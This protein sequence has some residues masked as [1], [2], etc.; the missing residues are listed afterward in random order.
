MV[1]CPGCL[2]T[3]RNKPNRTNLYP[4]Q[5]ISFNHL[6]G[7]HTA[8]AMSFTLDFWKIFPAN[9]HHIEF[10]RH[11]WTAF[12]PG[13]QR[14]SSPQLEQNNIIYTR[15]YLDDISMYCVSLSGGLSWE[16]MFRHWKNVIIPDLLTQLGVRP[17]GQWRSQDPPV[18]PTSLS[19]NIQAVFLDSICIEKIDW[20]L[21][22]ASF[23][24]VLLCMLQVGI[25]VLGEAA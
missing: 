1:A 22:I 13:S 4:R 15:Q 10:K 19:L 6:M 20:T 11:D 18:L 17:S 9:S 7:G 2:R 25:A 21:P 16:W 8:Q 24:P 23:D 14:E 12:Q 5:V 3:T